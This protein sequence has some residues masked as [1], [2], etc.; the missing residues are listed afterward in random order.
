MPREGVVH[1]SLNLP[2][3]KHDKLREIC[4]RKKSNITQEVTKLVDRFISRN[5]DKLLNPPPQK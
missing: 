1:F 2:T 5:S 4:F 3:D